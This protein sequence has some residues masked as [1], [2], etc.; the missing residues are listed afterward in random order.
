MIALPSIVL[1][2]TLGIT[3]RTAPWEWRGVGGQWA[4]IHS[5]RSFQVRPFRVIYVRR[6][7]LK[8]ILLLPGS[9]CREASRGEVLF[10]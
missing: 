4:A 7:T 9:Q 1:F 2:D 6:C 8:S 3:R 10:V 5:L